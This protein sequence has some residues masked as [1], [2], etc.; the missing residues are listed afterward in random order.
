MSIVGVQV[1]IGTLFF[2]FAA[3][4]FV[5]MLHLLGVPGT[6]HAKG[7]RIV[8]KAVGVLVVAL[9]IVVAAICIVVNVRQSGDLGPRGAVH[10]LF[11]VLFVPF[12][13]LK[14]LIIERYPELRN[15][16][17]AIGTI[18]FAI[19][20]VVFATSS[21]FYL[22]RAIGKGPSQ[23]QSQL[24]EDFSAEKELFVTRCSKCHRLDKALSAKM[25]PE[26]WQQTVEVMRQKDVTWIS[27]DEASKI[28]R[29]LTALEGQ[30]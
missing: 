8:H 22:V 13:V 23:I 19:V 7:L 3:L 14:V 27:P 1:L 5:L 15:R 2:L 17:L 24:G 29:F 4:D 6:T 12:V 28:A 16:L 10:F 11:A 9:Y 25:T 21:A 20:F 18:I 30:P 26:Q